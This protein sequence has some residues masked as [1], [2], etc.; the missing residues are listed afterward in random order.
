[1][2][3]RHRS[4]AGVRIRICSAAGDLMTETMPA[5]GSLDFSVP[6]VRRATVADL[7]VVVE[8]R[9]ALLRE[10]AHHPVYGRLHEDVESRARPVFEQQIKA[11]D[12]AIFL[13][14]RDGEIAGI[15]RAADVKGSPLL[16]P[17]RYCYVTSVYVRPAH[18]HQ[19]VLS[20]LMDHV[21]DWARGRGLTEMRLHNSSLNATAQTAWDQLG[22]AVNEEVR[23]KRI[24]P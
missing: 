5:E 3:A 6:R 9:L 21:E 1:M 24:G 8:L 15:A 14:E 19:G 11:T 18:R 13:A 16:V 12:Q 20:A 4:R 23:L 2:D 7:S 10:Y 22:F 17:D